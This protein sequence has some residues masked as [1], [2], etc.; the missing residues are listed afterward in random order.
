MKLDGKKAPPFNLEGTD[1]TTHS[2]ADYKG[3]RVILYFY[4]KDDTPGCTK[5]SC[6]F[7]DNHKLI[8]K[9]GAV[10]FG[11]SRD[12]IAYY[13]AIY[14]AMIVGNASINASGEHESFIGLGFFFG[15]AAGLAGIVLAVPLASPVWGMVAGTSPLIL[16]TAWMAIHPLI[17]KIK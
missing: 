13:A 15:P 10:I 11:V 3:K 2:L 14:Y 5:E 6:G 16:V 1:G 12:R 17:K 8:M 7:R 4:P 9:E